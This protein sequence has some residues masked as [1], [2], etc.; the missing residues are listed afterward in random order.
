ME[1]IV[2][3]EPKAIC[4]GTLIASDVLIGHDAGFDCHSYRYL[5]T[6]AAV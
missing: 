2:W 4:C 6:T 3:A 1:V 5:K